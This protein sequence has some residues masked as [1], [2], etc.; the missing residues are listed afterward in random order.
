M[1]GCVRPLNVA[2]SQTQNRVIKAEGAGAMFKP[3][4]A[5]YWLLGATR[6]AEA[7]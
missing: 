4:N 5:E 1:L 3:D 7:I 2:A 6:R